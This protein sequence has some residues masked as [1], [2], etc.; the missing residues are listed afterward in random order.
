MATKFYDNPINK[1]V[2]WGG[3]LKHTQGMPVSGK[4]VQ[5]FIKNSLNKK[6][7][8]LYFDRDSNQ[9]IIFADEEDFNLWNT[10]DTPDYHLETYVLNRFK[11]PAPASIKIS[12]ITIGGNSGS[13]LNMLVDNL[14]DDLSLGFNY[15][16]LDD[17]GNLTPSELTLTLNI[18]N[19]KG[20][21]SQIITLDPSKQGTFD[22]KSKI[23]IADKLTA[24]TNNIRITVFADTFNVSS[25]ISYRISLLNLK[26][27]STFN[28]DRTNPSDQRAWEA[29]DANSD[30]KIEITG[31]GLGPKTLYGAIDGNLITFENGTTSYFL[32][33]EQISRRN[34]IIPKENFNQLDGKHNIQF[35]FAISNELTSNTLY[36]DIVINKYNSQ[37]NYILVTK[38]LS[39]TGTEPTDH[40][41]NN[42]N[43]DSLL[44]TL[45]CEQYENIKTSFTLVS[46]EK[47]GNVEGQWELQIN[48]EGT[49]PPVDN[50]KN[51]FTSPSGTQIDYQHQF[52][53]DG[54]Y[55]LF[56]SVGNSQDSQQIFTINV[57]KLD[58]GDVVEAGPNERLILKLKATNKSNTLNAGIWDPNDGGYIEPSLRL[59]WEQ[60]RK[61]VTFNNVVWK[62]K[63]NGWE[64]NT[65]ILNNDAT[66]TIPINLSSVKTSMGLTFE[67]DFETRNVQDDDAI[68]MNYTGDSEQT[69]VEP[70]AFGNN[71]QTIKSSGILIK[72]CEA[73]FSATGLLKTNYK[74]NTR[75]KIQF[76]LNRTDTGSG[77]QF[78]NAELMYIVVNGI[79]DRV[80]PL[81]T[82]NAIWPENI[83]IGNIGGNVETIIHSIKIYSQA[84]T[85]KQCLNNYIIDSNDVWG[86]YNKNNLL[87]KDDASQLNI[88]SILDADIPVMRIYGNPMDSIVQLFDKKANVPVDILYQD[89]NNPQFNFFALNAWMSN[90]GTSSMNYPRRNLRLYFNKK[91]DDKTIRGF[92]P[93]NSY[94]Y[95]TYVFPEL[96]DSTIIGRLQEASREER[97]IEAEISAILKD[98]TISDNIKTSLENVRTN[99]KTLKNS[100]YPVSYNLAV[101]YRHAGIKLFTRS[102]EPDSET[103]QYKYSKVKSNK[104][105]KSDTQ[106]YAQGGY[107]KFK[108]KSLY[109]DR[110]TIKCDYAESSMSHNAGV[111]RLWGDVMRNV[112]VGTTEGFTFDIDGQRINGVSKPC[113]TNAQRSVEAYATSKNKSVEELGFDIRTS[114]DGYP[115]VVFCYKPAFDKSNNIPGHYNGYEPIPTFLGLH[116]IMTDKGSTPLFGF[117]DIY[118]EDGNKLFDAGTSLDTDTKNNIEYISHVNQRTEC[119]ECLQNGSELAQMRTFITD[120]KDGST[121]DDNKGRLIWNTFEARWPDNDNLNYTKTNNLETFIRFVNFCK[122]AVSVRVGEEGNDR[123]GYNLSDFWE[124]SSDKA[125]DLYEL[126][127][128]GNINDPSVSTIVGKDNYIWN[129]SLYLLVPKTEYKDKSSTFYAKYKE[130]DN[131]PAGKKI[132]DI[133]YDDEQKVIFVTDDEILADVNLREAIQNMYYYQDY[134]A[135]NV[136]GQ[137]FEPIFKETDDINVRATKIANQLTSKKPQVFTEYIDPSESEY[138]EMNT[139]PQEGETWAIFDSTYDRSIIR[140]IVND[141]PITDIIKIG[142]VQT[143]DGKRRLTNNMDIVKAG[144]GEIGETFIDAGIFNEEDTQVAVYLFDKNNRSYYT[145]EMGDDQPYTGIYDKQNYIGSTKLKYFSDEKY[146]HLDVW[147]VAAYYVYMMRFAAV[148]QVI[149]NTMMTTE[150]GKHYYFINYDNDTILGVRNDGL[151]IYDWQIDRNT[152]DYSIGAYAYAGFGSV[153]WNLLEA[154]EDF[155]SK[156]QTIANAMV[157][158]NALTYAIALDM[159]NVKQSGTWSELLYNQSELYKYIGIY[160]NLDNNYAQDGRGNQK[161]LSFLHGSRQSHREWWLRHRFDLYDSKW[162]AGEYAVNTMMFYLKQEGTLNNPE[163]FLDIVSGSKFYYMIQANNRQ[164]PGDNF[165]ELMNGDTHTFRATQGTSIGDP[166][167]LLGAYKCKVIDFSNYRYKLGNSIEFQWKDNDL[168][169]IQE[170]ILGGDRNDIFN[171]SVSELIGVEKLKTLKKLDVRTCMRLTTKLPIDELIN[172]KEFLADHSLVKEFV[173]LKGTEYNRVTLPDGLISLTLD[174]NSFRND[175]DIII[176]FEYNPTSSLKT[177]S[178]KNS[179]KGELQ[180]YGI[181]IVD[182]LNKWITNLIIDTTTANYNDGF[183]CNIELL[184]ELELPNYIINP[185]YTGQLDAIN[186]DNI[187]NINPANITNDEDIE[188]EFDRV[189]NKWKSYIQSNHRENDNVQ[190]HSLVWLIGIRKLFGYDILSNN[191]YKFRFDINK[192]VV[193]I[194]GTGLNTD[195]DKYDTITEN[196]YKILN[197]YIFGEKWLSRQNTYHFDY[198]GEKQT[199]KS[200]KRTNIDGTV[201]LIP[202][203]SDGASTY[204]EVNCGDKLGITFTTFPMNETTTNSFKPFILID[205]TARD[206]F[207]FNRETNL[208]TYDPDDEY[209]QLANG[210]REEIKTTLSS[211]NLGAQFNIGQAIMSSANDKQYSMGITL[212]DDN[213]NRIYF[214]INKVLLPKVDNSEFIFKEISVSN[215]SISSIHV[216]KPHTKRELTLY[217]QP[218]IK[219]SINSK[220]KEAITITITSINSTNGTISAEDV[221]GGTN[222]KDQITIKDQQYNLKLNDGLVKICDIE[223]KPAIYTET[224]NFAYNFKVAFNTLI[225]GS[226]TIPLTVTI[227]ND[228]ID[229]CVLIPNEEKTKDVIIK[230][231]DNDDII[232]DDTIDQSKINSISLENDYNDNNTTHTALGQNL[233]NALKTKGITKINFTEITQ[234]YIKNS[235]KAADNTVNYYLYFDNFNIYESDNN[236]KLNYNFETIENT[237][238]NIE[239]RNGLP[240]ITGPS[241][242]ISNLSNSTSPYISISTPAGDLGTYICEGYIL[243]TIKDQFEHE[244]YLVIKYDL[245]RLALDKFIVSKQEISGETTI[246]D[247]DNSIRITGTGASTEYY[248]GINVSNCPLNIDIVHGID[249]E[250]D[251]NDIVI[252][253]EV[254]FTFQC[255]SIYAGN[256]INWN[257]SKYQTNIDKYINELYIDNSNNTI[258][259]SLILTTY[260]NGQSIDGTTIIDQNSIFDYTK[261][262]KILSATNIVLKATTIIGDTVNTTLPIYFEI[263]NNKTLLLKYNLVFNVTSGIAINGNLEGLANGLYYYD[264]DKNI[265][266]NGITLGDSKYPTMRGILYLYGESDDQKYISLDKDCFGPNNKKYLFSPT[267]NFSKMI[268][269]QSNS[270][271]SQNPYSTE[272]AGTTLA[273]FNDLGNNWW[274]PG[275]TFNKIL[276][277]LP[278]LQEITGKKGINEEYTIWMYHECQPS[279]IWYLMFKLYNNHK[280]KYEFKSI[281]NENH[282]IFNFIVNGKPVPFANRDLEDEIKG[283]INEYQESGKLINVFYKWYGFIN[284]LYSNSM[285]YTDTN[286]DN[287]TFTIS[288]SIYNQNEFFDN[289]DQLIIGK[290]LSLINNINSDN[291][292]TTFKDDYSAYKDSTNSIMGLFNKYKQNNHNNELQILNKTEILNVYNN[293]LNNET[294]KSILS[295]MLNQLTSKD[296]TLNI[297]DNTMNYSIN[298][299]KNIDK[300]GNIIDEIYSNYIGINNKLT[301]YNSP[302]DTTKLTTINRNIDSNIEMFWTSDLFNIDYKNRYNRTGN[303]T[304]PENYYKHFVYNK[305]NNYFISWPSLAVD[306]DSANTKIIQAVY[307]YISNLNSQNTD[308]LYYGYDQSNNEYK[309][310]IPLS[311]NNTYKLNVLYGIRFK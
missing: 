222:S 198:K 1:Q 102:D 86:K 117:E 74:E 7:G 121:V 14:T 130:G 64:N 276:Y 283:L 204:Y 172:L 237:N 294:N 251:N 231:Y 239:F 178:I 20:T 310:Y 85:L 17:S 133:K 223:Y 144:A 9:Y 78:E 156:V 21:F 36:Y 97:S 174:N 135:Q 108:T 65:L 87:N 253:K 12:N 59:D 166:M 26:I 48:K 58:L 275:R 132:G 248:S 153:L 245:G 304:P 225:G 309:Y 185:Y 224:I 77:I 137:S 297:L 181:D 281:D 258:N 189:F 165:K 75:Q 101:E 152:Y 303:L 91:A 199:F 273:D 190:I 35:Y 67:I 114:C 215:D 173:G 201:E 147:K 118:D 66:V 211:N 159:F 160:N 88:N 298:N 197:S 83:V 228:P 57:E 262:N 242:N 53:S 187:F 184:N 240:S 268:Y 271:Q 124:I 99:S 30:L 27:S 139:E 41:V 305:D 31:E 95:Q 264:D 73:Q 167:K 37:A 269:N 279:I 169:M 4:Q 54:E 141:T 229:A 164:L 5:A 92:A 207:Q 18:T 247:I 69:I 196:D 38:E 154:D 128:A 113:M 104:A 107:T 191:E 278:I 142:H 180:P 90:Q 287:I 40:F 192:G 176:P 161:Y 205:N 96:T 61:S 209:V 33:S 234:Y 193:I 72:A 84:L 51:N 32:G 44:Y 110:W 244:T 62:D 29:I 256:V 10:P 243:M 129:G 49:W 76:I 307:F 16:I 194:K 150:D 210:F 115:I 296:H 138:V 47:T 94:K 249:S 125:H 282:F 293:I 280:F 274:Q 206:Y 119:W 143:F 39:F 28:S 111:G 230:N 25:I 202:P 22:T 93:N 127:I 112:E 265:Y 151:L 299:I 106:Y 195:T 214:R 261:T 15:E 120:T 60:N 52:D 257:D 259:T 241:I 217:W 235:N 155:M 219:T 179:D 55:R 285:S 233:Y 171:C 221:Y 2:D 301:D 203:S 306:N 295:G 260:R 80:C 123:D 109:T 134:D 98:S 146:N 70:D 11:A 103:G 288:N 46:T 168:S 50:S 212:N 286:N 220:L 162:G 68:I 140:K 79:L 252:Q 213:N 43:K 263:K 200:I 218:S 246:N 145:D 126:K 277:L 226:Y 300:S 116:N 175:N 289:N 236:Y 266:S 254:T 6:F 188:I 8:Y 131:I 267:S 105:L 42:K 3:D 308:L 183:S 291:P 136:T 13:E 292:T 148:D 158:S 208:W 284:A 82:F 45:K 232:T 238:G 182:L 170:L 255:A 19:N 63:Q 81:K 163:P 177:I 23:N 302:I 227:D 56:V 250:H 100:Y 149:K 216:Q 272:G 157:T 311:L 290:A 24:G 71:A 270:E 89:K 34:V 186:P 122:D